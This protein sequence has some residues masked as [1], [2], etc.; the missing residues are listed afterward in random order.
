[1]ERVH[2]RF[3]TTYRAI[4]IAQSILPELSAPH[5]FRAPKPEAHWQT[6]LRARVRNMAR[7]IVKQPSDWPADHPKAYRAEYPSGFRA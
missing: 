7:T 2:N 3:R 4:G 5:R 6:I 1:M